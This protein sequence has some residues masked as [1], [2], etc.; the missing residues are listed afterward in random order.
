MVH[1]SS[2]WDNLI[3]TKKIYLRII[4]NADWERFTRNR[5]DNEC[6]VYKMIKIGFRQELTDVSSHQIFWTSTAKWSWE[7]RR[8]RRIDC[9]RTEHHQHEIFRGRNDHISIWR[10]YMK[11][12]NHYETESIVMSQKKILPTTTFVSIRWLLL[13]PDSILSSLSVVLQANFVI[14][15]KVEN[16]IVL[17]HFS[18]TLGQNSHCS[19]MEVW[20]CSHN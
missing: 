12:G 17:P 4:R 7:S 9:R 16:K 14:E 1:Y 6:R 8:I 13:K 18:T 20:Y 15:L 11:S 10:C 2:Y 5:V 3:W 19:K